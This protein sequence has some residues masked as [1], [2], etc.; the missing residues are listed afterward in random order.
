[1]GG[2]YVFCTLGGAIHQ[3]MVTRIAHRLADDSTIG[4]R[5]RLFAVDFLPVRADMR[6]RLA[7]EVWQVVLKRLMYRA[8]EVIARRTGAQVLVTGEALAGL[9]A[10]AVE[11]QRHRRGE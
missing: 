1:M 4:D 6:A 11:P 8:G 7:G 9:I 5:P 10:A 3:N 2:D